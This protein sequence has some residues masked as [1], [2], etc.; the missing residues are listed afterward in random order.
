MDNFLPKTFILSLD[1]EKFEKELQ[2]FVDYF[3]RIDNG[4]SLKNIWITKPN[5]LN[6]GRGI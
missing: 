5:D 1:S 4:T 6:R 3:L 2:N